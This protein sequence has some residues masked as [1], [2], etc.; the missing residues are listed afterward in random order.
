MSEPT[1]PCREIIPGDRFNV[2]VGGR[3]YPAWIDPQGAMRFVQNDILSN[4]FDLKKLDLNLVGEL[5]QHGK[6]GS[7]RSY[8]EFYMLLEYSVGGW[9]DLSSF[10]N[11]RVV[12]PDWCRE[13]EDWPE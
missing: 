4:L 5:F 9:C 10:E 2:K 12:T 13:G 1:N 3:E 6:L 11:I 7:L 8:G